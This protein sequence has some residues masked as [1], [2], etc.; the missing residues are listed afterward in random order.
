MDGTIL[1]V[2]DVTED[3]DDFYEQTKERDG[4]PVLERRAK[5]WRY[6]CAA[7]VDAMVR[8]LG[9]RVHTCGDFDNICTKRRLVVGNKV[10]CRLDHEMPGL[11]VRNVPG[12]ISSAQLVLIADYA[13]GAVDEQTMADIEKAS[14]GLEIIADFH[15]SRS[16]DFYHCATALKASWDAPHDDRPFIR[17]MG[18]D[19]MLLKIGGGEIH[20]PAYNTHP[21][22]PCG[23]GDMVLATLG[24]GRLMGMGWIECCQWASHNAAEVCRHWGSVPVKSQWGPWRGEANELAARAS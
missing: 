3:I 11:P 17:T 23:A 2:G 18:A 7:A 24:V 4:Y 16:I 8:E 19:G 1:V 9:S 21:L 14:H 22:D 5:G 15:P 10:M 13:K 12:W 6:G 20:F